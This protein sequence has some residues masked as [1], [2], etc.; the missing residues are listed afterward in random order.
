MT[1]GFLW[2]LWGYA[3]RRFCLLIVR[4]LYPHHELHPSEVPGR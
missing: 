4:I 3:H 1:D 2:K